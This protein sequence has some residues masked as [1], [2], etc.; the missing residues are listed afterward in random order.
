MREHW[1]SIPNFGGFYEVSDRGNVRSVDRVIEKKNGQIAFHKGRPL[2][3]PA[4][5]S[6]HLRVGLRKGD[7]FKHQFNVHYLVLL[8]FIGPRPEGL[9]VRHLNGNPKDNRLENLCYGTRSDNRRDAYFH[10]TRPLGERCHLAKIS[11][12]DRQKV[13]EAKGTLSSNKVA[14]A[15]GLSASYVRE[16]WRKS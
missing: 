3:T 5:L 13:I 12:S 11:D 2:V 10:G 8:A 14:A 15:F 6:G 1:K 4:Q 9:E 7:E 16:L